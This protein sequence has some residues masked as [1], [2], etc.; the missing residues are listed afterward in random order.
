MSEV[1]SSQVVKLMQT[2]SKERGA[3]QK[4]GS[5][6]GGGFSFLKLFSRSKPGNYSMKTTVPNLYQPVKSREDSTSEAAEESRSVPGANPDIGE[7]P[8]KCGT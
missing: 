8:P 1:S 3:L 4:K 5:K 6:T 7:E 2:G